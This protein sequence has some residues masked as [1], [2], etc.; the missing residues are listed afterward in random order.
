MKKLLLTT[1]SVIGFFAVADAQIIFQ[2]DFDG[3]GGATAGGAGTYSFPAGWLKRNVDNRTPAASVSYVNEAWERREDFANNVTDSCAFSTSWYSPAGAADDW[4]WTPLIGPLPANCVLKWNAVTYDASYPDGYSVRIMTSSQGPPTGGT[5]VIGNQV[6][7]STQVFSI[8]AEN[9][10]WTARQLSLNAYA[11]QSIYIAFRN[12][13]N[14]KFI[15]LIDDVVVEVQNTIDAQMQVADTATQYTLMPV[16]QTTPLTFA[17]T[18]RNVGINSLTNVSAQVN[19]FNGTTNVYSANSAVTST[20]A[21]NATTNFTIPSFTPATTGIYTVQFIANQ[22]TGTDQQH[23]NDTLYQYF[24]VLD[25]TYARDDGTVVGGLGIGA[26]NGG[27]LGQNFDVPNNDLLT[28]IGV[29]VTA[30]YTGRRLGL[31]VWSTTAGVPNA[32]IAVTDTILYPDDSARYYTIP[33]YGGPF[34]ITPGEYTVTAIEFNADS[35]IQ[36]GQTATVFTANKTWVFWPTIP[37]GVWTNAEDF[38]SQFARPYVIRP[39]FG[40]VCLNNTAS[41]TSTQASCL[42]CADGS[43]SVTVTGTSGTPTYSWSPSGGNAATA[44]G[45]LQGTYI[46]SV[47]DI[48][49]CV[50]SDTVVVGYDIC[51]LLSLSAVPVSSSC[52]TCA[53]GSAQVV[54]TGNN[55]PLTYLWSN[56]GTSDTIQ[57]VLPGSYSVLVTDSAGCSDTLTINV[58]YGVCGSFAGT[59]SSTLA[60]CGSCADGTATITPVGNNGNV[61]YL[62]SNGDTTATAVNLLPGTYTVTITDTAGCVYVDSVTVNFGTAVNEITETGFAGLFP[63]PTTGSFQLSLNFDKATDTQV[64][65]YNILGEVVYTKSISGAVKGQTQ[66]NLNVPS[67]AYNV[68]VITK[69]ATQMLPLQIVK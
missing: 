8:A 16:S 18:I 14:D 33:M 66:I 30:G 28:S 31:A 68:H 21:S 35:T 12:T 50:V 42:T 32:I 67:G 19:V 15:L 10:T 24:A 13:S 22:T 65:I 60:N 1:I 52:Q 6:T 40:D 62:W 3:I 64:V 23:N 47:T 59:T 7:N 17:G 57:N 34:S 5:G 43:A 39:N 26:G 29:Y 53:D 49:G 11:G 36:V 63:N 37:G 58:G 61:T 4:M 45:L 51:G 20:L 44:T 54:V 55:G 2:E 56:G 38:G 9:T 41:A 25:S 27:Y 46:V 69:D 48:Y